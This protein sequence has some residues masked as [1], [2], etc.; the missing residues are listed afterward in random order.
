M[1]PAD[2]REWPR[3]GRGR[4]RRDAARGDDGHGRAAPPAPPSPRGS[5][6][7]RSR[8]GGCRCRSRPAAPAAAAR[9]ASSARRE[10][11]HVGPPAHRHA[12]RR[13][14]PRRRGSGPA[15][16]AHA[17]SSTAGSSAAAVPSTAQRAPVA[18]RGLEQS[19][20]RAGRRPPRP[21]RPAPPPPSP[22]IRAACRGAPSNAPSRSTTW[23]RR[24]PRSA[25]RRAIA[26]GSSPKT[27]ALSARPSTSRTQRP[28]WRSIAGMTITR[29]PPPAPP[30]SRA[31]F[32]RSRSPQP[33]LFSGW[34]W[35]PYSRS[36]TTSAGKRSAVLAVRGP[37][38]LRL[39]RGRHLGVVRVHEVEVRARRD[40]REERQRPVVP[41]PVPAHVG[42]LE[43]G[44]E[45]AHHPGQDVE[46]LGVA[47]L[48][49]LGEEELVAEADA[50]IGP[51]GRDVGADRL[52][53]PEALEAPHGVREG[54][55][56]GHDQRAGAR[57]RPGVVGDDD[58]G[59]ELGQRLPDAA[60]VAPAVVDDR[61]HKAPFVESTPSM[62]GF[63]REASARARPNAL[64]SA[65]AMWWRFSP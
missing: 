6:R 32:A 2:V 33:W 41:E 60:E 43:P 20:G 51:P 48:L 22:R 12:R 39:E 26:T 37:H 35:V 63:I 27:V 40:A 56:P 14:R 64:N 58:L 55:V 42:H 38:A 13:P 54:A 7:G 28:P 4:R 34:N 49:A 1:A 45:P 23:S 44:R 46:A 47:E 17:A 10:R 9:R 36:R 50:E 30:A 29:A 62:R 18:E 25:Q 52:G 3:A 57:H 11:E 8:P 61:D 21:A 15:S 19:R 16:V 5:G 31:K 53:E 24:A 59:H 65:S